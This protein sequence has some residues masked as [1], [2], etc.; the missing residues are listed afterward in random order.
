MGQ[1]LIVV[2]SVFAGTVIILIVLRLLNYLA[3]WRESKTR[4]IEP[5]PL[6]RRVST[7]GFHKTDVL[8]NI[9]LP[10]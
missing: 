8:K 10:E 9:Y 1:T 3:D 7:F 6:I 4:A 5:D 2:V